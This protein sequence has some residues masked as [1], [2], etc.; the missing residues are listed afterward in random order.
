MPLQECGRQTTERFLPGK[1]ITIM[2]QIRSFLTTYYLKANHLE[3]GKAFL[4]FFMQLW[5]REND[6]PKKFNHV[7]G[8]LFPA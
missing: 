5:K 3:E 2:T 6:L 7:R 4:D 8:V 1:A